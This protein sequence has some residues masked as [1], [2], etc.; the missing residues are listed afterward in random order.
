MKT[1]DEMLLANGNSNSEV[2]EGD[3]LGTE[4][5]GSDDEPE[6]FFLLEF[7]DEEVDIIILLESEEE[8]GDILGDF[9]E[10]KL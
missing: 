2:A 1:D 6:S 7:E 10:L 5:N 3:G 4:D 8:E 9:G